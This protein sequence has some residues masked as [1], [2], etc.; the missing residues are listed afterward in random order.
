MSFGVWLAARSELSQGGIGMI[1]GRRDLQR[2]PDPVSFMQ[3]SL[4]R[5]LKSLLGLGRTGAIRAIPMKRRTHQ[6]AWKG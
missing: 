6:C 5:V 1:S 4:K 2:A 3:R